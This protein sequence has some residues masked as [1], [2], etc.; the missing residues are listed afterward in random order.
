[1]KKIIMLG[2]LAGMLLTS[3]GGCFI[4]VYEDGG[5]DRGHGHGHGEEGRGDRDDHRR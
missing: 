4:P 2:I 3:L 1:M 5:R